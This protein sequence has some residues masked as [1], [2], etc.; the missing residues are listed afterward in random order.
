VRT[1][2]AARFARTIAM[3]AT[4][5]SAVP[6]TPAPARQTPAN[7]WAPKAPAHL[8]AAAGSE[9]SW[10]VWAGRSLRISAISAI[11]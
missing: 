10:T 4:A 9:H 1:F 7:Q 8:K 6:T 3:T 5:T 11:L 2:V